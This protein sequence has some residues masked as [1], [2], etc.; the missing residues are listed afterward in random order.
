[1]RMYGWAATENQDE[2]RTETDATNSDELNEDEA[3]I[4][5]DDASLDPLNG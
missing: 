2:Q 3:M 5:N 4:N 1:M